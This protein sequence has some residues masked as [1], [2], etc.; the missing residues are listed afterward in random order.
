MHKTKSQARL[1]ASTPLLVSI[2][3]RARAPLQRQ[4]YASIKRAILE[5][6]LAP[7]T[8]LPPTR[9]LAG[10][11]GISR[12]TVV[13][14][15]DHLAAEGY[16]NGRGS[17]GS[18]VAS[19]RIAPPVQPGRSAARRA[20]T[21][22][23]VTAAGLRIVALAKTANGLERL[24]T[25]PVPFRIG[26]PAFDLFPAHAWAR[27]YARRSRRAGASLLAY[28]N[29][30]GYRPLREAIAGYVG[31]ARGVRATADQVILTRGVQQA[32]DLATRLLLAPGDTAWVEDPGYLAAR[33]LLQVG[34]ARLA[35]IPVDTEGL[36]VADGVRIAPAARL[37]YVSPSHQFPL[38]VTM[39]LPRRLALL[40]WAHRANAWILEDDFDSE[41]RYAGAPIAALQGLDPTE[42]VLYLGTFS[43]TLF[44]SIRLGYLIVPPS[45]TDTFRAAHGLLDHFAPSLEQ[46][47]LC[48]FI[49]G[50]HYAG[51]VRRMRNAYVLRMRTLLR[52]IARELGDLV[53]VA[54]AETGMH[55][56]A[57][58]RDRSVSDVAVSRLARQAGVEVPALSA[59]TAQA[60]C[61][62]A[63]L[64][65]FAA[66]RPL[67]MGPALRIVRDAIIRARRGV[68]A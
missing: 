18:F 34:G 31:A 28:G 6:R 44:P 37:A 7:G 50:G 55:V 25:T 21:S 24:R 38:A 52:A 54:P 39:S 17:A 5:G 4:V 60:K 43:K 10:D 22:G 40:E 56:V 57:W 36:V 53:E 45:L 3:R 42:R 8:R 20:G 32:T 46:A 49:T 1:S 67:E 68:V 48:D 58:L 19:L 33:A 62:P 2:D 63:L 35:P 15:F 64:M 66:T 27:L 59:Y 65:G 30:A 14:A 16:L 9:V 23:V 26:E 51:H 29:G 41:F 61:P 11:L 47:T 13:L 12:T